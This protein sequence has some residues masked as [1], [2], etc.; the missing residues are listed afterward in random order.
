MARYLIGRAGSEYVLGVGV[1]RETVDLGGV[2]VYDVGGL[3]GLLGARV[4][5]HELLVVA[6]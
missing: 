6:H 4:P 3:G 1:E 2:R 5:Q